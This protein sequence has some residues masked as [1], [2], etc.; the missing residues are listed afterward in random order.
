MLIPRE[1][2]IIP[3][4]DV[5]CAHLPSLVGAI[6]GVPGIEA[7]KVGIT[8]L[9]HLKMAVKCV[10]DIMPS[11]KII[12]DHQKAANDIPDL[13]PKFAE[14]LKSI[15]VDA[16]ILFPFTGP[17]TQEVWTKACQQAGLTVIVGGIMTHP[18]FLESEG[19]YIADS[20]PM[21]IYDMACDHGV[22]DFVVPGNKPEWIQ[23][24]YGH[25]NAKLGAG[26]FGLYAPG[27]VKQGGVISEFAKI[28][29]P[30]WHAIVG[31]DIYDK[32][33]IREI[34]EAAIASTA[35]VL[36]LAA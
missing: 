11:V 36:A 6:A 23:T 12:Y 17:A 20:A 9:S 28:A 30:N 16:A 27:F 5:D 24:I 22:C 7:V 29:G 21:R 34:H 13:G 19:G 35:Q 2:S 26:K 8:L 31:R 25:L 4:M 33:T 18:K 1:K 3:A 15:G 32:P 14:L 10:K